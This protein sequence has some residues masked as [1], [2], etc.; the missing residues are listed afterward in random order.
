MKTCRFPVVLFVISVALAGCKL[1]DEAPP[2][3]SG[4]PPIPAPADV[5]APPKDALMTPSGI[6]SKVL[7]VG[8]GSIHPRPTQTVTVHYTGWTTD[9]QMFDSSLQR[10]EP[11]SFPL[12]QVI[13]GWTEALQL[14]V[15]GEKRRFWIP[16]R[17][18]YDG[19]PGKPQGTL[20]FEIELLDF[21]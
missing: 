13:P 6:A 16:G 8:L 11:T 4:P 20:C 7:Q 5:A 1:K 17:L 10:G 14:M 9:G 3:G 19:E 21:K 12:N 15:I 2:P 18:A